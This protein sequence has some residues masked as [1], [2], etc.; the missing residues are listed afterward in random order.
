MLHDFEV[1]QSLIDDVRRRWLVVEQA[2]VKEAEGFDYLKEEE[3]WLKS[4]QS[5]DMRL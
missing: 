2:E 5:G 4:Q 1:D 3:S